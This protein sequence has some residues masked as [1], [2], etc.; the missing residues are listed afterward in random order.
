MFR[1]LYNKQIK[2]SKTESTFSFNYINDIKSNLIL[3]KNKTRN[4]D[5]YLK[6]MKFLNYELKKKINTYFNAQCF[7]IPYLKITEIMNCMFSKFNI[8]KEVKVFS[9]CELPGSFILGLN[10]FF[11]IRK[12]KFSWK[13]QSYESGLCDNFNLKHNYPDNWINLSGD[14]LDKDNVKKHI[15]YFKND[16]YDLYTSDGSL[17]ILS[18]KEK[19]M[20]IDELYNNQEKINIILK[21]AEIEVGISSLKINGSMIIKFFTLF[22]K[23]TINN[24]LY[25]FNLF[26]KIYFVKPESSKSINSEIYICFIN[27]NGNKYDYIYNNNTFDNIYSKSLMDIIKELS[28]N[29]TK[30]I[31]LFIDYINRPK[32]NIYKFKHNTK[33]HFN[34]RISTFRFHI[35]NHSQM[36]KTYKNELASSKKKKINKIIK[37]TNMDQVNKDIV[38][39]DKLIKDLT[40]RLNLLEKSVESNHQRNGNTDSHDAMVGDYDSDAESKESEN[41]ASR[42]LKSKTT[43]SGGVRRNRKKS[44][45]KQSNS[46]EIM[47]GKFAFKTIKDLYKNGDGSDKSEYFKLEVMRVLLDQAIQKDSFDAIEKISKL[48]KSEN[49]LKVKCGSKSISFPKTVHKIFDVY[50]KYVKDYKKTKVMDKSIVGDLINHKDID[51]LINAIAAKFLPTSKANCK[52]I[53]KDLVDGYTKSLKQENEPQGIDENASD[54]ISD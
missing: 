26:D 41:L 25:T 37:I 27:Y 53:Y 16:K 5:K 34:S 3:T 8:K 46:N 44:T 50:F 13:A 9:N 33:K 1:D 4:K 45:A 11:S 23:E 14:M 32:T 24:L 43:M 36:M 12:I 30:S 52:K 22:E 15:E 49:S 20:D 54:E 17:D 48:D 7:S 38:R 40:D 31:N 42:N 28:L 51:K 35:L 10:H 6:E 19:N 39:M 47:D 18:F 21:Q 2:V 29:Q